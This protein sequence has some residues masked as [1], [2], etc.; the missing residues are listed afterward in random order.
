MS[1]SL[2]KLS[3]EEIIEKYLEQEKQIKK[4][5]AKIKDFQN[6]LYP[7]MNLFDNSPTPMWEEEITDLINYLGEIKNRGIT[8]IEKYLE[9][10]PDEVSICINKIKMLNVN[11]ATIKLHKAKS[12]EELFTNLEEIFTS[13]S[14]EAFI[15]EIV[16]IANGDKYYVGFTNAYTLTKDLIELKLYLQITEVEL[17]NLTKYYAIV[18]TINI[19]EPKK[20]EERLIETKKALRTIIDASQDIAILV[21]KN[22]F[23]LESNRAC[24]EFYKVNKSDLIGRKLK[25]FATEEAI[26]NRVVFFRRA[27]EEKKIITFEND[28]YNRKWITTISPLFDT[29]DNVESVVIY[30]RDVTQKY[31]TEKKIQQSELKY[32]SIF[33]NIKTSIVHIDSRGYI[34]D[35]NNYHIQHIGKNKSPKEN[36]VGTNIL[37]RNSIIKAGLVDDYAELLKGKELILKNV[38]FPETTG[39]TSAYFNIHGIPLFDEEKII[40]AILTTN[41]VTDEVISKEKLVDVQ[42]RLTLALEGAEIGFWEHDIVNNKVWRSNHWFEMLGYNKDDF[43]DTS[44]VW[45]NLIHPDDL[46]NTLSAIGENYKNIIDDIRIEHR[47]RNSNNNYQW[48]LNW[49]KITE[50][51]KNGVPLRAAGIHLDYSQLKSTRE[52][53]LKSIQRYVYLFENQPTVIWEEDFSKI[54]KRIDSLKRSGINNFEQYFDD[55]PEILKDMAAEI[56]VKEMNPASLKILE[57][58]SYEQLSDSIPDYFD[59]V[60]AWEVFK[61]EMVALAN[62]KL[63]FESEISVKTRKG[64]IKHLLLTLSVPSHSKNNFSSILVSFQDITDLKESSLKLAENENKYSSLVELANDGIIIAQGWEIKFSNKNFYEMLGYTHDEILQVPIEQLLYNSENANLIKSRFEGRIKGESVPNIYEVQAITKDGKILPIEINASVMEYEGKPAVQSIVRDISSRK[65]A[66]AEL[67]K[68]EERFRSMSNFS[69]VGIYETDANGLGLYTN[70]RWQEITGLSFNESLGEGWISAIHPDDTESVLKE[71]VRTVKAKQIFEMEYR[72]KKPN[73]EIRWVNSRANSIKSDDQKIIGFVGNIIDITVSKESQ[74]TIINSNKQLKILKESFIEA[75]EIASIGS[76]EFDMSANKT[77]WSD[78]MF[79]ILGY[80]PKQVEPS[81]EIAKKHVFKDDVENYEKRIKQAIDTKR[82]FNFENRITTVDKKIIWVKSRGKIIYDKNNTPIYMSGT[83]QDISEQ[84]NIQFRNNLLAN[85]LD[86]SPISFIVTD[87]NGIIT[88]ISPAL[89]K[90]TGYT[91]QEII[92]LNPSILNAEEN[93]HDIQADIFNTLAMDNVWNGEIFNKKKNGELFYNDCSIFPLKDENGE[94]I[95]FVS[96]N[97]DVTKRKEIE[98]ELINSEK[99]L[100]ET[101]LIAQLGTYVLDLETGNWSSSDVLDS[102]FGIGSDFDRT[103]EAWIE[104]LHPDWKELMNDYFRHAVLETKTKFDKEYKIIRVND[105]AERWVHGIGELKFDKNNKPISMIGSIRDVTEKNEAEIIIREQNEYVNSIFSSAPVGIGVVINRFLNKANPKLCKMIGYSEEELIGKSSRIFYLTDEEYLRVGEEKYSQIDID[106]SGIVETKWKTKD[107][108]VIDIM[109]SST[110]IDKNDLSKGVTFTALDITERKLAER[111]LLKSTNRFESLFHNSPVPLWEETFT[112]L[113]DYIEELRKQGINDFR[114]YFEENISEVI[115]CSNM[116]KIE[117]V[118]NATLQLYKANNKE[119]LLGNLENIFTENSLQVFRE[120]IIAI[121][122]GGIS[123]ECESEVKTLTG[124]NIIVFLKLTIQD[125]N[126]ALLATVDIT[127]RHQAELALAKSEQSLYTLMNN[128]PGMAYQCL[129]DENWTMTFVTKECSNLL[130]FQPDQIIQNKDFSYNELIHPDDREYVRRT[131]EEKLGSGEPFEIEYRIFTANGKEKWVWERGANVKEK[132][133]GLNVL[134]GVIHD[135][136]DRKLADKVLN[137]MA[138]FNHQILDAAMDGYILADTKGNIQ[139]VN[140]S[141]CKMIG[142]SQT[143]LVQMNIQELAANIDSEQITNRIQQIIADGGLS[144]KTKHKHKNGN[145][146]DLDVSITVVKKG[147]ETLIAALVR[148]ISEQI[149]NEII[150]KESEEKYRLL[151]ENQTDLVVEIDSENKFK[152]VSPTY[153]TLF[154]KNEAELLG[155][156]FI[157]L[158]HEDDVLSTQKEM[159]KLFKEPYTCR[160]EQRAMTALGWRWLEW[161]DKAVIDKENNISSIFGV[162]RDITEKKETELRIKESEERFKQLFNNL[163]S[164]VAIYS[165]S[166]DGTNFILEDINKAGEKLSKVR[167]EEVI[168]GKIT[169]TF[170]NVSGMGLLEVFKKVNATNIPVQL[171]ITLYKDSRIEY[172]YENYIYKLPT[173]QIVAIYEDTSVEKRAVEALKNNEEDLRA[174]LNTSLDAIVLIS[175]NGKIIEANN[176]FCNLIG[177]ERDELLDDSIFVYIKSKNEEKRKILLA[178]IFKTKKHANYVD[179]VFGRIW[180]FSVYPILDS[181]G[182]VD[183]LSIFAKDITEKSIFEKKL[184]ETNEKLKNLTR[185]M[186]N[187]REEERKNVAREVHDNLGQ[188]LTALNLDISWIKQSIP[189]EIAEIKKQFDPV[190]GLINESIITVQKISTELR[191]GILDDLGLVNAIQWQ[192]NEISRRSNLNFSLNL[193]KEELDL[194]DDVKTALFRVYQEALTNIVRHSEASK[195]FV[196][197]LIKEKKLIFEV[198]DDGIGIIE[199]NISDFRSYGIMG[200]KERIDSING[201]ITFTNLEKGTKLLI[202]IPLKD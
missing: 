112:E 106:G 151:I 178:E 110:P 169:E 31:F 26:N 54:K 22:G 135:I 109:L 144:F 98:Q 202:T 92:G 172:W 165:A 133:E 72:F 79:I 187:V 69:S 201:D 176:V 161:H 155:K 36:Y 9:S 168:G 82:D 42:Q 199:K 91:K 134:E 75:Q 70:P 21:D 170:P 15:N 80:K 10:N 127:E 120:E 81:Y 162:G 94:T 131:V 97:Q 96:F 140:P 156:S 126:R 20:I 68:S 167:R 141:Y 107:K 181:N 104:I 95:A 33:Q 163:R 67:H 56:V 175:R 12:K 38:F 198:I 200:M 157:P 183:R 45:K 23:I 18:S 49:G 6:D 27:F 32:K 5:K 193:Y 138:Q 3:K 71:W 90:L 101:Q 130:G 129:A 7:S 116:V 160:V 114:E 77:F 86:S 139:E 152:F 102:I 142:Y 177:K 147:D 43:D 149:K 137:E 174:I 196:N 145:P 158:V 41:D 117:S 99:H 180:D 166:D 40:G 46:E 113:Y 164:G 62:G 171:P 100:R 179:E 76:W 185:Y 19:T 146:I 73:G 159:E 25:H 123:F 115:K 119:E 132:V 48:I 16:A 50:R 53:Y 186:N 65:A 88:E 4:F 35:I 194:K 103:I 11:K 1:I 118:N 111:A 188:K 182:E 24:Q 13:K 148:D 154:G 17:G 124:E 128:I 55:H 58:D 122:D 195:V 28:A 44:E 57:A 153:C 150:I 52:E 191:P 34:T 197:L 14:K 125:N 51:D 121:A 39:G 87:L 89:E 136:T 37:E 8:D 64:N 192:S 173:G 47:L 59:S 2:D 190:L 85:I 66:Q 108:N 63:H 184:E 84:K 105:K 143:E 93:A 189:N 29:N 83:V 74:E 30:H 61:N 60:S 78:Q